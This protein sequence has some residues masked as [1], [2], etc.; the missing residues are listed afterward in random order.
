MNY[1]LTSESVLEGWKI[2]FSVHAITSVSLVMRKLYNLF[3]LKSGLQIARCIIEA[4]ILMTTEGPYVFHLH[5][6][7]SVI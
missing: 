7:A 3:S 5:S 2:I 6:K 4:L 1:G